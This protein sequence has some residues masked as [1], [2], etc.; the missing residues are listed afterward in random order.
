F[1]M[2]AYPLYLTA[3]LSGA[4][5][6]YQL[7]IALWQRPRDGLWI[8][9]LRVF[10]WLGFAAMIALATTAY[11]SLPWFVVREA[12]A[13]GNDVNVQSGGRD[14]PFFGAG[15]SGPY[16][17]G[18]TFRVSRA[19]NAIVRIPLPERRAYQIV[20][21]LDPVSPEQQRAVVLLNRQLLATL[22]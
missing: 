18:L 17:D 16:T 20:L 8:P 11:L 1:T 15:W 14:A 5:F 6:C 19:A 12:I 9:H 13:A 21:R 22:I 10:R 4:A 2:H 7:A 3:S